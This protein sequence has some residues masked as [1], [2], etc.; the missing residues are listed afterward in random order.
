MVKEYIDVTANILHV[1]LNLS[2]W[3]F[4][5]KDPLHEVVIVFFNVI[6]PRREMYYTC[7][8]ANSLWMSLLFLKSRTIL[9]FPIW[10]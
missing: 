3:N 7:T 9:F 10:K 2:A 4:T 1:F 6:M 8:V 5:I